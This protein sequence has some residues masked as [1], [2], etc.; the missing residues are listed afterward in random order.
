[1]TDFLIHVFLWL[2]ILFLATELYRNVSEFL[3]E[4]WA[5]GRRHNAETEDGTVDRNRCER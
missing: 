2:G 4:R 5:N 3:E 1:M